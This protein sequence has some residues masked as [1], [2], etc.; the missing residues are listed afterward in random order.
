MSRMLWKLTAAHLVKKCHAFCEA[1]KYITLFTKACHWTPFQPTW[2]LSTHHT[3]HFKVKFN[4]ILPPTPMSHLYISETQIIS[5]QIC[6]CIEKQKLL[7][8][9]DANVVL[10]MQRWL[11]TN[12]RL[13]YGAA[14]NKTNVL[15]WE[16]ERERD[17]QSCC[18]LTGMEAG[19]L[20]TTMSSSMWTMVIGSE[21]T[22]TSCLKQTNNAQLTQ[23]H[24]LQE[25]QEWNLYCTV[26]K[27]CLHGN[28]TVLLFYGGLHTE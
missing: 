27:R 28:A 23:S 13:M 25:V 24:T 4:I 2:I 14:Q 7:M 6:M 10:G 18:P 9:C 21:V 16:R 11:R 19:L 3:L 22:G 1:W 12:H 17:R 26:R 5:K 8:I 15:V 20:T